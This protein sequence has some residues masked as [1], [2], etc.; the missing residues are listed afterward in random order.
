MSHIR[1]DTGQDRSY[2]RSAQAIITHEMSDR[3]SRIFIVRSSCVLHGVLWFNY[4][5][6]NYSLCNYSLCCMSHTSLHGVLWLNYSLCNFSGG[7]WAGGSSPPSHPPHRVQ[8]D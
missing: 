4:S 5:L 1:Q 8:I 6:C 3:R 7:G 2:V